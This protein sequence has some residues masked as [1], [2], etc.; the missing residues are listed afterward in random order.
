MKEKTLGKIESVRFGYGGYQGEQFGWWLGF[1]FKGSGC[2]SGEGFWAFDPSSGAKWTKEDQIKY[3]GKNLLKLADLM[4][5]AKV[6]EVHDLVGVPIEATFD[7]MKLQEWR[8][9]G[10]VL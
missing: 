8:I 3:H 1:S 9:L 10:E 4:N 6:R 7:C 2:G 5:K